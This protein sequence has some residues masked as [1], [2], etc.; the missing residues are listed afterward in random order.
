M[1][2]AALLPLKLCVTCTAPHTLLEA[3][4]EVNQ[5]CCFFL[6]K[7]YYS[8]LGMYNNTNLRSLAV[9]YS[10]TEPGLT[11]RHI[12]TE[13]WRFNV[14][15]QYPKCNN[16]MH[17]HFHPPRHNLPVRQRTWSV[18]SWHSPGCCQLLSKRPPA[19]AAAEGWP[20]L[21]DATGQWQTKE[22]G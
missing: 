16:R 10:T 6:Y 19:F 13:V 11:L 9:F 21:V 1:P 8:V 18:H 14:L 7:K 4:R 2:D 22:S 17:T 20:L 15:S 12:K 5:A 3:G